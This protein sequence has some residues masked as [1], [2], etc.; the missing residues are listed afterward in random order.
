MDRISWEIVTCCALGGLASLTLLTW[1]APAVTRAK[2]IPSLEC[3]VD[4]NVS[5][6][7]FNVTE[8]DVRN[9]TLVVTSRDDGKPYTMARTMIA[10]ETCREAWNEE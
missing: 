4:D 9:G 5:F 6:V 10:G 1:V 7:A 3:S 2:L 8:W